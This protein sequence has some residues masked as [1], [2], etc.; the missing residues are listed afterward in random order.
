MKPV[1]GK[2]LAIGRT[3]LGIGLVG[4]ILFGRDNGIDISLFLDAAWLFAI[5]PLLA[6][7]GGSVEAVRLGLLC[8]SQQAQ[9][10][11]RHGLRL[12]LVSVFFNFF[13]PGG[14]GGDVSKMYYL[15]A[16]NPGKGLELAVVVFVDRVTG[17]LGLIITVMILALINVPLV[18]GYPLIRWLLGTLAAVL[19]VVA[20][21]ALLFYA[22]VFRRSVIFRYIREK[23]P[24]QHYVDRTAGAVNAFRFHKLAL[25]LAVVISVL[26]NGAMVLMF[27]LAGTVFMPDAAGATV[28]FLAVLGMFANALPLTPGGLGVGEAAFEGL[29]GM[30]GMSAGA[31][32]MVSWRLGML[33]LG[34]LGGLYYITGVRGKQVPEAQ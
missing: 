28:C 18:S 14:T 11:F 6:L 25:L 1:S 27:L 34:L 16:D 32:L 5:L 12:V 29:F 15:A 7:A 33:P 20:V 31:M 19:A 4:Y 3:V 21:F 24:L 8:R 17:L 13:V 30:L 10:G 9:L 22:G 23:L 2:I 26:G